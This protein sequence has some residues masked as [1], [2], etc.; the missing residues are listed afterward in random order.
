MTAVKSENIKHLLIL[1]FLSFIW[2]SSFILIKKG[3][4]AFSPMQVGSLRILFAYIIIFP[5][6]LKNFKSIFIGRWKSFLIFGLISNFIPAVLFSAA[7]TGLSSSLAGILNALTPIFTLIIGAIAFKT[8]IKGLQ[9]FGLFAGFGGSILL[10]FVQEGGAL[11]EFNYFALFV[12]TATI[13]Y[14]VAA[15]L[16]KSSFHNVNPVVLTS[17]G[18]FS[19]GPISVIYLLS[20]NFLTVMNS[21][22]EAWTSLGYIFILGVVG[23]ALALFLFNR[24]IQ[25]TTAVF[26]STVTYLIPITAVM[27]GFID[28]EGIYPLHFL[29]MFL[30]VSGV[31]I[32]NKS[33]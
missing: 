18:L 17:M 30:I 33:K 4:I 1:L 23:T 12:I 16:V 24:L 9:N 13:C 7:E 28:G 21:S 8:K 29:G 26:A 6:A 5:I 2:G 27:W 11:G 32:I 14:G 3:L 19:V 22:D 10:S 20:S 15:N 25:N 31:Y